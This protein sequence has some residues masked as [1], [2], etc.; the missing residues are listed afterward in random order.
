MDRP[1]TMETH[2]MLQDREFTS[3]QGALAR[4]YVERHVEPGDDRDEILDALGLR[5]VA[6]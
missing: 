3:T 2:V 6:G 4:R 1:P 5:D